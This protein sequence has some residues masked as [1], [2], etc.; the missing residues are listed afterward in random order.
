MEVAFQ[1]AVCE[2]ATN[3][4]V[5]MVEYNPHFRILHLEGTYDELLFSNPTPSVPNSP[6]PSLLL[7]R[8]SLLLSGQ[9]TAASWHR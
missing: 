8:I 2:R 6:T 3:G 4:L 9:D 1:P 7:L 5:F